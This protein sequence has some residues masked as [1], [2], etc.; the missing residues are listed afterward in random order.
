MVSFVAWLLVSWLMIVLCF[1]FLACFIHKLVTRFY[2][3]GSCGKV[4]FFTF[5]GYF[6]I[7]PTKKRRTR[8]WWIKERTWII[9]QNIKKI[10]GI[11]Q[12]IKMMN[13]KTA[14]RTVGIII[15]NNNNNNKY[16]NNNI[17]IRFLLQLIQIVSLPRRHHSNEP[18]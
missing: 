4:D 5:S 11:Q 1:A 18:C 17:K 15:N 10:K 6:I 8:R 9:N 13:R 2:F 12:T 16:P 14:T 3:A 7:L